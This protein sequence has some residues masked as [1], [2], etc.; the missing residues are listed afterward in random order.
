[1]EGGA[2]GTALREGEFA[3]ELAGEQMGN[4]EAEAGAA[5]FGGA[6]GFEEALKVA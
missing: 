5:G 4:R 6:A 1:M 3:A 2:G